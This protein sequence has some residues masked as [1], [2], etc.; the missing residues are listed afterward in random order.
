MSF[1]AAAIGGSGL[2]AAGASIYGSNKQSEAAQQ[3]AALMQQQRTTNNNNAAP[4]IS[5]GQGANN[6]L[7]SFY[8]INGTSPALGQGALDA[9]Q[10]S[11]DYQFA[12]SQGGA[13]LDNSAAAKGG[14][15]G[16][17]QMLAA[18]QYGQGLATQNLQNYL[19]RL[20]TMSG[21][22]IQ[23]AG[24]VAGVNTYGANQQGQDIMGAGTAQ[25][26]GANGVAGAFNSGISNY[27]TAYGGMGK[28]SYGNG[29]ITGNSS[30]TGA[31]SDAN[32]N[33]WGLQNG[34]KLEDL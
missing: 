25:A 13:A 8:G 3:A 28:S 34:L 5:G 23:A 29:N 30:A 14:L 6:L 17:N 18:T 32:Y 15:L 31:G 33:A 2:L 16:G 27:L 26:A 9:F 11:P 12:L 19:G 22:G 24:N 1:L 20:Q 10:K 4:F 7:Q 21:Q